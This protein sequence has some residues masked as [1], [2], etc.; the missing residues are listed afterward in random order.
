ML[1][2]IEPCCIDEPFIK[3]MSLDIVWF[4][5]IALAFSHR[6]VRT[7]TYGV[8]CPR[9]YPGN[10]SPQSGSGACALF[11]WIVLA[12]RLARGTDQV[13]IH[14]D[15]RAEGSSRSYGICSAQQ[16]KCGTTGG[17]TIFLFFQD[18]CSKNTHRKLLYFE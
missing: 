18:A 13:F 16:L 10:F 2:R 11:P 14:V 15:L 8:V 6:E 4:K 1:A 3:R 12:C 5:T 17:D 9:A 7:L